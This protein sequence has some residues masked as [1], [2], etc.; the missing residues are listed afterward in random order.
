MADS[1]L[2][3]STDARPDEIREA[4]PSVR[5][6]IRQWVA[7]AKVPG[8]LTAAWNRW[9]EDQKYVHTQLFC[10]G[11]SRRFTINLA[12]RLIQAKMASI[13]PSD[14]DVMIKHERPVADAA[15][16]RRDA[17]R[18]AHAKMV[19]SGSPPDPMALITAA[20]Q[21]EMDF[22]QETEARERFASTSEALVKKLA[23]EAQMTKN[24]RMM[25]NAT[26]TTGLSWLKVGW[27]EDY[28]RDSVGTH[29]T[30]DIQDQVAMLALRASE[31][32]AGNF[33]EEDPRYGE[34]IH[35][36]KY[37]KAIGEKVV[38]GQSEDQ[39]L[40]FSQWSSMADTRDDSV[41]PPEW[42]P[43]PDR[44]QGATIDFVA[45]KSMRWD[46]RFPFSQWENAPWVQ[47]QVLYDIDEAA[48][49]FGLTPAER[50]LISSP[51]RER[52]KGS[53]H[54]QA[55]ANNDD[56]D[57]DKYD[58]ESTIQGGKVVVWDRWEKKTRRHV[59][60]IEGLDRHLIDE[61]PEITTPWFYPWVTQAFNEFDGAMIPASEV[62]F[63][64]KICD[65]I[66]QRL[67]D[68]QESLWASMK[69]YIVKKGAFKDG[70]LDKLRA[71]D[72]HDVIEMED[73]EEIRKSFQEIASDDWNGEKYRLEDL[74]RLLEL[75]MGMSLAQ[76]GVADVA[77]TAT[78]ASI[79]DSRAQQ[80]S[81]RHGLILAE[82]MQKV[83]TAIH[84]YAVTAL[85]Q[86]TVRGL[87]GRAAYWPMP[88][89]RLDLLRGMRVKVEAAGNR[90]AARTKAAEDLKNA[91]GSLSAIL[92]LKGKAQMMGLDLDITPL[93]SA[94]LRA[95]DIDAGMRD[96]FQARPMS[97]IASNQAAPGQPAPQGALPGGAPA[98]NQSQPANPETN[99]GTPP[100]R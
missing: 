65:A 4:G 68:S 34:L 80:Q 93:M 64:R 19:S 83:L 46:W 98:P 70:E 10:D 35:L 14:A 15:M 79:A 52:S 88:P 54:Q 23:D 50:D 94:A 31:Y 51:N 57:P 61:T 2:P 96:L 6:E 56:A 9:D 53:Q 11:D 67:T 58:Y 100:G 85:S 28:G 25:T 47:E 27:Q 36:T 13:M 20:E 77:N 8:W 81:A 99:P 82:S 59:V 91:M 44:W 24:T 30:D 26:F 42:L 60:F 95:S 41:A 3:I 12:A 84:H 74:Y 48:A 73:P 33:G 76:L 49:M 86:K 17:M 92:D 37:V 55:S 29:R 32:A 87:V 39:R 75:V 40:S 22:R 38:T 97:A 63:L 43:E 45:A 21:A 90:V 62:R 69:R 72:P 78:E 66:N 89:N 7:D 1:P 16:V 18:E 5:A 71:S